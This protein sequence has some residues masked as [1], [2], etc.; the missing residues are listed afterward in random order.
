MGPKASVTY[1]KI[2]GEAAYQL[3]KGEV[4]FSNVTATE[5]S[6]DAYPLNQYEID[7]VS[8]SDLASF[9][10]QKTTLDSFGFTDAQVLAV[11]KGIVDSVGLSETFDV[12]L[13]IQRAF[14][15]S[16]VVTDVATIAIDK[17]LADTVGLLEALQKAMS[18]SKADSVSV[19]DFYSAAIEKAEGDAFSL[20]DSLQ[21]VATYSRSVTD[22]FVLDELVNVSA[23][24][25]VEK[26]N[27]VYFT[28]DF[29]YEIITIGHNSILNSSA[30]NTFTFNL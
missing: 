17:E 11:T 16:F 18:L 1:A 28:E 12:V 2:T 27:V 6:L 7:Q 26:T 9:E 14:A 13:I 19:N 15:D 21:R 22:A 23:H 25:G 8:F 3:A 20:S 30:L 24:W 10:T 29:S 5:V 4:S